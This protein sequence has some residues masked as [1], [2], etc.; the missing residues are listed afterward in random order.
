M[1]I[2]KINSIN[3]GK[4]DA[5]NA[6][7]SGDTNI[8]YLPNTAK[9]LVI[10]DMLSEQKNSLKELAD[11]QDSLEKALKNNSRSLSLNQ[12]KILDFNKHAFDVIATSCSGRSYIAKDALD[13]INYQYNR[14][15]FDTIV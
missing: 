9:L 6:V 15:N 13:N 8:N 1:R 5:T 10:Y 12:K 4:Y 11:R 14:N 3:F 2:S 7:E